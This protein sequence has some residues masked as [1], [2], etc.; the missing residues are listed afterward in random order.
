MQ[1]LLFGDDSEGMPKETAAQDIN[2]AKY[3]LDNKNWRAALSRYQSAMVLAPEDPEVYW[4]L[5]VS[6]HHMGDY[7]SARANYEKVIEYDP[8]SKHGKE[9]RKALK[10]PEIANAKPTTAG[11]NPQ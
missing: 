10:E 8:D 6:Q 9:A 4:G 1:A 7:A 3:Y 5:A 2:V 11:R